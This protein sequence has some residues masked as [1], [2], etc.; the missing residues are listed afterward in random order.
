[1][2]EIEAKFEVGDLDEIRKRL[3]K[4]GGKLEWG[5]MEKNLYFDYPDGRLKENSAI[6]RVR[7]WR[8]H[9]SSVTFKGGVGSSDK[10]GIKIRK[11]L[12]TDVD[13]ARILVRIFRELGL[14]VRRAYKKRREHW[15]LKKVY[16]ELD[17]LKGRKFVEIEG[18]KS[19]IKKIAEKLGLDWKD[20]TTES[21]IDIV[22]K[23]DGGK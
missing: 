2:K 5:G 18:D 12:Q 9:S 13:S 16:V 7:E 14:V 10:D 23:E 6:L 8:G 15:R 3:E 11:E 22:T 4:L 20:I 17:T 21:Y 19:E 1:M